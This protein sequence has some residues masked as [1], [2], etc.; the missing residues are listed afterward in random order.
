MNGAL[1]TGEE[2]RW[3]FT[4][5]LVE[6]GFVG[7]GRVVVVCSVVGEAVG[8]FEVVGWFGVD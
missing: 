2:M 1:V 5:P 3:R 8:A 7:L 4:Y 6:D